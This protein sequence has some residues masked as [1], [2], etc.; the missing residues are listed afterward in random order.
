MFLSLHVN[1]LRF[2]NVCMFHLTTSN[3]LERHASVI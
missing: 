2:F 1:F 3:K